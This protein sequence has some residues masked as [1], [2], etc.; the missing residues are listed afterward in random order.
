[1]NINQLIAKRLGGKEFFTN[2]PI[3]RF[4][5]IKELK[6]KKSKETKVIDFGIGEPDQMADMKVVER[7]YT[8]AKKNENRFYSDNGIDLFKAEVIRYMKEFYSVSNLSMNEINHCI[9]AKSALAILP[10][11][12]INPGDVL[13]TTSPGYVVSSNMCKWL[14]G[15]SYSLPLL[16]QNQFLPNY[17]VIPKEVLEKSKML[18]LN[19]PNNPTGAIAT[20]EFFEKTV[21]FAKKNNIIVIHDAAYL[22]LTFDVSNQISFLNIAGAK[23][24]GVEIHSFSKGYNMT[25]WRLGF[26]AGNEKIVN[27]FATVKDNMDSGQFIP[28]QFAGIT[29]MQN[30]EIVH[31]NNQKYS[32]RHLLLIEVLKN[33][34]LKMNEVKGGFYQYVSVPTYSKN[35][36]VFTTGEEFATYLLDQYGVMTIPYDDFGHY[37]R[38]SVTYE[39]SFYGDEVQVMKELKNRLKEEY[40]FY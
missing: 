29:A 17:D 11:L 12:F 19:Y 18:Y 7:L 40:F 10:L 6:E 8:E 1:M 4:A 31:K 37:V 14:G 15:E 16:A 35:G 9:G 34:G 39:T 20:K 25:G 21:E 5:K 30:A 38:F 3:Y 32:R 13:L 36:K 2:P 28:I 22:P 24:V 33:V 23:D 26:V 27:A